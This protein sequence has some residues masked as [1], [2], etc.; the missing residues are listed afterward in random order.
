VARHP[1]A[2]LAEHCA[3]WARDQGARMSVA[4]MS[5]AIRRVGITLKKRP[6]RR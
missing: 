6:P 5:R 4:T 3:Q 1:D 2:T